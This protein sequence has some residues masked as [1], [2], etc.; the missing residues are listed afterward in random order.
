MRIFMAGLLTTAIILSGI[1]SVFAESKETSTCKRCKLG[2][3]VIVIVCDGPV[4]DARLRLN[5]K[6][7]GWISQSCYDWR[8]DLQTGENPIPLNRFTTEEGKKFNPIEYAVRTLSV[9]RNLDTS[10]WS[11]FDFTKD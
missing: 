10:E 1:S 2:N 9:S 3:S 7:T 8:G 5:C 11:Y 4:K 6:S